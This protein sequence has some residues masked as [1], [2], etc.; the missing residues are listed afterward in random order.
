M[1]TAAAAPSGQP[2]DDGLSEFFGEWHKRLVGY[3]IINGCPPQDA[4]DVV[5]DSFL[6]VSARWEH[7]RGLERPPGYLFKV[8]GRRYR[9]MVGQQRRGLIVPQDPGEYLMN[10]PDPADA[11]GAAEERAEALALIRQLP[12]RQ[13]QVFYL[14][15]G[16]GFSE[17][18]TAEILSV[19][20]G[21]VKSQM[22][23]AKK[24]LAE[25]ARKTGG[26]DA[27]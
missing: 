11:L 8:A 23:E 14:R 12:L 2:G 9:R 22:H 18:E 4:D 25:L 19:T 27:R 3:L 7:V 26:D 24:K 5:Q 16:I 15:A 21:T 10:F 6:A 17:A 1:V 20:T 13:G